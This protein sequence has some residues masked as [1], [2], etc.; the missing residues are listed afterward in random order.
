MI[1]FAEWFK[2]KI[3]HRVAL[4][5]VTTGLLRLYVDEIF[6]CA[7]EYRAQGK[8]KSEMFDKFNYYS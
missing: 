5:A 2:S 7:K 3:S 1:S 6:T 8:S 4:C